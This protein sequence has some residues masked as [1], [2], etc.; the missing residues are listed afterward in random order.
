M[1]LNFLLLWGIMAI[2]D[3]FRFGG[4]LFLIDPHFI[5]LAKFSLTFVSVCAIRYFRAIGLFAVG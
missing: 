4:G 2:G 3:I 5:T 1:A